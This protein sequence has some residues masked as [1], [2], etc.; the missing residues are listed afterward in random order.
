MDFHT[1]GV[2]AGA[3]V[4]LSSKLL[5][6]LAVGSAL[7]GTA[8][9]TSGTSLRASNFDGVG[10]A[11]YHPTGNLYLDGL[12]GINNATFTDNRW[13]SN[14]LSFI[15]GRRTAHGTFASLVAG[16]ENRNGNLEY[17][18][19]LRADS[20]WSRF[21]AMSETSN[22]TWGLSFDP[23]NVTNSSLTA[24]VRA[25]YDI[26]TP[27]GVL[28]PLARL[29]LRSLSTG[30]QTQNLMYQDGLGPTYTVLVPGTTQGAFGGS[31]GLRLTGSHTTFML[32]YDFLTNNHSL[33]H[34][35]RPYIN[36]S[37]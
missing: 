3:D 31:F 8:I 21:N 19:Y 10:Y 23:M 5:A 37:F 7:D 11:S 18:P 13:N 16:F 30:Q 32:D 1:D 26:H 28:T 36:L 24:G 35:L 27:I 9:G 6:G 15:S 14:D 17:A 34:A 25:S 4:H 22:Q 33:Q 29:E 12:L 2:T 20:Q